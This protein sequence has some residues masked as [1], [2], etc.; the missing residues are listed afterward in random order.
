MAKKWSLPKLQHIGTDW[1][2]ILLGILQK[3]SICRV[4]VT[5]WRIWHIRNEIVHGKKPPPMEASRQF[6]LCSMD[7]LLQIKYHSGEDMVK[8]KFIMDVDDAHTI[9]HKAGDTV[10][11]WIAPPYKLNTDGSFGTA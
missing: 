11:Q 3:G 4:L 1:L 6:L 9:N 2:L 10:S 8:G 5:L 7:S